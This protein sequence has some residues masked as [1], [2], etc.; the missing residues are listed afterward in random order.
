MRS[1][2]CA[3]G[4]G[5]LAVLALASC[6]SEGGTGASTATTI[7]ISAPEFVTIPPIT[8]ATTTTAAAAPGDPGA[9]VGTVATAQDYTV[10]ANDAV[11]VIAAKHCLAGQAGADSIAAFNEW[12]DGVNHSLNPGDV[13]KIPPGACV[14]GGSLT[15]ET[16]PP[17]S[18][19]TGDTVAGGTTESSTAASTETSTDS[20]AGGTYTVKDGDTLSGIA[21]KVGT[22]A[23]AIRV[24]NGWDNVN[25]LIYAGLK[26]KLPAK[27]G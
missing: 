7:K 6:S 27:S 16:N 12:S 11:F 25:H 5:A 14:N 9:T 2:F 19:A 1:T 4:L 24:A 22:T 10:V 23:E 3:A 17:A 8:D 18:V 26:I 13:I 21:S 20:S 15:A